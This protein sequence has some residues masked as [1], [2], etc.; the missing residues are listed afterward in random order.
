MRLYDECSKPFFKAAKYVS[1]ASLFINQS[2]SQQGLISSY[3]TC[4]KFAHL[5]KEDHIR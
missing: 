3:N 2:S 4:G 5:Y 1:I